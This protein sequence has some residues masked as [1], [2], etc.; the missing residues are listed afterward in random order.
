[1]YKT[2]IQQLGICVDVRPLLEDTVFKMRIFTKSSSLL[3]SYFFPYD[4][5]TKSRSG[6][7]MTLSLPLP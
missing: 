6:C 2:L 3:L 4:K 1:M 7:I 5:F